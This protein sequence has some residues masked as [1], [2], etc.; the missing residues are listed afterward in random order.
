[1]RGDHRDAVRLAVRVA[2]P[3]PHARGSGLAYRRLGGATRPTPACAGITLI[4]DYRGLPLSA[5]PRMRGDHP[6]FV[7]PLILPTGPPPHA[8]GSLLGPTAR[9]HPP[10]P[11]PACAG[12]TGT[13]TR[14]RRPQRAHPRMR[15]DHLKKALGSA[16]DFGPPPHARGSRG[17]PPR[18]A[19][20]SRPTP[21]CA[22]ITTA[23]P[24]RS[25]SVQAHPRMRG[26]HQ[27]LNV[28]AKQGYGPPPHARGSP[29]RRVR[30][31]R[32]ARPTP[33][34][35]G[36]TCEP[37][38]TRRGYRAHPRMRGDHRAPCGAS[39]GA[40]GPPPHARGSLKWPPLILHRIRPTPAC[41]GI[42]N[43]VGRRRGSIT[44]HP[45]MRGD[46]HPKGGTGVLT[47]G[48]PPHARGSRRRPRRREFRRG[49]TPACAGITRR[50]PAP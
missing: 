15:G 1:M 35:A 12:I 30:V 6:A 24:A 39:P 43:A 4:R 50:S 32:R 10:R 28:G 46:H 42:T 9:D 8:R 5:H 41:A 25:T 16:A 22:G 7:R 13:A 17:A 45:R 2:G 37:T 18:A 26:D 29:F 31:V 19:R 11:T 47:N 14:R 49:P 40:K 3:P 27:G 33:A 48:P 20:A 21:A 36:I 34:C 44:A 38:R 23:R